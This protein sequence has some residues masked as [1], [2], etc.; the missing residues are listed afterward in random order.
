[1]RNAV[2]HI[3]FDFLCDFLPSFHGVS[4]AINQEL[5]LSIRWRDEDNRLWAYIKPRPD[6]MNIPSASDSGYVAIEN[7]LVT[8][9]PLSRERVG[10][11]SGNWFSVEEPLDPANS[12]VQA[13]LSLA[14]QTIRS[15]LETSG[16]GNTSSLPLVTASRTVPERGQCVF[17]LGGGMAQTHDGD[18]VHGARVKP[19]NF[20]TIYGT[21]AATFP[22]RSAHLHHLADEFSRHEDAPEQGV[23]WELKTPQRVNSLLREELFKEKGYRLAARSLFL[24]ER[25]DLDWVQFPE[26]AARLVHLFLFDAEERKLEI[27]DVG[28]GIGYALPVLAALCHRGR[29]WIQQPELHLHPAMQSGMGEA[30]VKAVENK[31]WFDSH[32]IVETHSENLLLRILKMLRR[33]QLED[34]MEYISRLTYRDVALIYFDPQMD[35]TTKVSRIRLAPDGSFVDRWPRGF[36]LE[37]LN[38]LDP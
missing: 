38:D 3:S 29:A 23:W 36:F 28:S 5:I 11:D 6:W 26:T 17:A 31:Q 1:M 35:G 34:E 9:G 14:V 15:A 33:P 18:L 21:L 22:V 37:R 16:N 20:D 10:M 13:L 30:I 4:F 2:I 25:D 27:E 12:F 32:V 19:D 7:G 8:I 24:I